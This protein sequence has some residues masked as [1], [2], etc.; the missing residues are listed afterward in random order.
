MTRRNELI[1]SWGIFIA[2]I[3]LIPISLFIWIQYQTYLDMTKGKG[4][5][6]A[7]SSFKQFA[8]GFNKIEWYTEREHDGLFNDTAGKG[9]Y[10]NYIHASIFRMFGVGYILTPY[11]YFRASRMIKRKIESLRS[12]NSSMSKYVK[13][14]P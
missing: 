3:P 5:P 9:T 2:L 14:K 4:A 10:Y 11:G 6:F 1:L 13:L 8:R 7:K 12:A